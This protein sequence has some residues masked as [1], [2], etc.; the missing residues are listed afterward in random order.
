MKKKSTHRPSLLRDK[1]TASFRINLQSCLDDYQSFD[2]ELSK[3]KRLLINR[4]DYDDTTRK[5]IRHLKEQ[6]HLLEEQLIKTCYAVCLFM[7]AT[8]PDQV[9]SIYANRKES[10][11][12]FTELQRQRSSFLYFFRTIRQAIYAL[13]FARN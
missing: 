8:D 3:L 11:D 9:G 12:F 5:R 2:K 13:G 6:V 4:N 7:Q 1:T 10:G